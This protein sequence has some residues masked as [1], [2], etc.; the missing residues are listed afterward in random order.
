MKRII[1]LI[2]TVLIAV[3]CIT[4]ISIHAVAEEIQPDCYEEGQLLV[5]LG[6]FN[7]FEIRD[8]VLSEKVTRGDFAEKLAALLKKEDYSVGKTYFHDS[9]D[10]PEVNALAA[11]GIFKGNPNG[12]FYP[13]RNITKQEAAIALTRALGYE[14]YVSVRGG[15]VS[16]YVLLAKRLDLFSNI[17]AD[18]ELSVAEMAVCL[19]NALLAEVYEIKTISNKG[20]TYSADGT[21]LLWLLY[22]IVRVQGIVTADMFTEFYGSSNLSGNQ[23]AINDMVYKTTVENPWEYIGQNVT[24]FVEKHDGIETVKYLISDEERNETITLKAGEFTYNNRV[25]EYEDKNGRVREIALPASMVV[26]KNHQAVSGNYDEAFDI[27]VGML[28]LYKNEYIS[29]GNYGV[30]IIDSAET[31]L[32][33]LVD[34]AKEIIYTNN[35]AIYKVD[36]RNE[37]T[38]YVKMFIEPSGNSIGAVQLKRGNLIEVYRSENGMYTKIC[39]CADSIEGTVEGISRENGK[40][41]IEIN[42]ERYEI[43]A[44]FIETPEITLGLTADFYFDTQGKIAYYAIESVAKGSLYAY[45]YDAAKKEEA[46]EDKYMV[47]LCDENGQHGIYE[48]AKNVKFDGTKISAEQ[49]YDR[50]LDVNTGMAKRQLV[51]FDTNNSGQISY[52][53]SAATSQAGCE[54]DGTLWE[55]EEIGTYKFSDIYS[56]F[57]PKYPLRGKRT[58]VF[59]IPSTDVSNPTEKNFAVMT[60]VLKEPPFTLAGDYN[61]GFYKKTTTDPYMDVVLYELGGIPEYEIFRNALIVEEISQVYDAVNGEIYAN[62]DCYIG[63]NKENLNFAQD[64]IVTKVDN[65]VETVSSSDISEYIEPGDILY[66][67][68]NAIGEIAR[69]DIIYDCGSNETNWGEAYSNYELAYT[70]NGLVLADVADLYVNPSSTNT[71]ALITVSKDG[72]LKETFSVLPSNFQ[73]VV[74]DSSLRNNKFYIGGLNDLISL[75]DTGNTSCSKIFIQKTYADCTSFVIY[76]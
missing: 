14:T 9:I 70:D 63:S 41:L 27:K 26:I 40:T 46:F 67:S 36:Y 35:D 1:A 22:N 31:A 72:V 6:V 68:E 38:H 12:Y 15:S 42:G 75:A 47:K 3:G 53:D 71:Q 51:I 56:M 29:S 30:A 45:V 33:E 10:F 28:R 17:S 5:A 58:K 69:I 24:A 52:I 44:G 13:E 18:E 66:Y 21:T 39:L 61:V 4:P 2:I 62:M 76:K 64:I 16:E 19:Y 59:I 23:I 73:A 55:V 74:Y 20:V 34:Y 49:A 7:E 60:F 54:A 37:E 50:L 8:D 25:I 43:S 48:F 65:T 57:Y 32:V 11:S